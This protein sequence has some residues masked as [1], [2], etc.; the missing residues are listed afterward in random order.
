MDFW[1]FTDKGKIVVE[2]VD[3]Y[4]FLSSRGYK[5][6]KEESALSLYQQNGKIIKEVAPSDLVGE[7]VQHLKESDQHDVFEAV[8]KFGFNRIVSEMNWKILPHLD[9]EARR[10]TQD[11]AFFYFKNGFVEINKKGSTLKGYDQLDGFVYEDVLIDKNIR[12]IDIHNVDEIEKA[13]KGRCF[14]DF[15]LKITGFGDNEDIVSSQNKL[16]YLMQ[17]LGFLLH[18]YKKKGATDFAVILCDDESGGSGKGLLIQAIEKLINTCVEDSKQEKTRFD[19]LSLTP[20]TRLRVYNDVP[21]NFS[22]ERLYNEITDGGRIEYKSGHEK[23]L[24]YKET[25]KTA[26]T[27]NY[28]IRGSN[29][30]DY[31][32]QAVYCM[33]EYFSDSRTVMD[34]YGHSFFEDWGD[35]DWNYFYNVMFDCVRYWLRLGYVKPKLDDED[36]NL[37]KLD[38]TFPIEFRN[39]VDDLAAGNIIDPFL[40]K[41]AQGFINTGKLFDK[42]KSVASN[43]AFAKNL[44]SNFFGRLLKQY[45]KEVGYIYEKNRNRSGTKVTR[46]L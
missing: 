5:V 35:D 21:R 15:L 38:E 6:K 12:V 25:W 28:I 13:K 43:S 4:N 33:S 10:H 32:R 26:I 36:Y 11:Q 20:S 44:T 31:R 45:C 19:S 37:R 24:S 9:K 16:Q 18:D 39:F 34:E 23:K 40:I 30:S 41:D 29:G 46:P 22:F 42:F 27:S 17:L 3:C 2:I 1:S 8:V 14:Y 7:V